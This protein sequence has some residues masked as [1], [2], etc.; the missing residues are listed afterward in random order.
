MISG[1]SP[2]VACTSTEHG[3]TDLFFWSENANQPGVKKNLT[4]EVLTK[5][6]RRAA[7][8]EKTQRK[9]E[10]E[11]KVITNKKKPSKKQKK[12]RR[13]SLSSSREEIPLHTRVTILMK[14]IMKIFVYKG[15]FYAK[16]KVPSVTGVSVSNATNGCMK[17]AM[18]IIC[19]E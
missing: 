7:M 11:G 13:V 14:I 9:L 3:S 4:S 10:K 5:S 17:I 18:I 6:D 15:Y 16:K 12:K 8:Q 1:L 19:A 2:S